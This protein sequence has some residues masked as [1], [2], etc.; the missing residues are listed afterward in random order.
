[1]SLCTVWIGPCTD[2]RYYSEPRW[3]GNQAEDG[4]CDWFLCLDDDDPPEIVIREDVEPPSL[5]WLSYKTRFR[6]S[7]RAILHPRNFTPA[8]A[9]WAKIKETP[10]PPTSYDQVVDSKEQMGG[11]YVHIMPPPDRAFSE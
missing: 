1:M 8:K 3:V 10:P 6:R 11:G 4:S 7:R 9:A 5:S 2:G